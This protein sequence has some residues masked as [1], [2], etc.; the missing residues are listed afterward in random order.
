MDANT[1]SL[2]LGQMQKLAMAGIIALSPKKIIFDEA[3]SMIDPGGRQ[4]I[5]ALID[6]L[7]ARGK[8]L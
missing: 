8:Q 5:L 2:S 7:H 4:E 6:D 1:L 3:L